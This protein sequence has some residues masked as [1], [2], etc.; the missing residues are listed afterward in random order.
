MWYK[1][2]GAK[3]CMHDHGIIAKTLLYKSLQES[4]IVLQKWVTTLQI[5]M[6]PLLPHAL[7]SCLACKSH[8]KKKKNP[9]NYSCNEKSTSNGVLCA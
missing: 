2:F 1:Y 5:L 9:V 4:K 7:A 6:Q 3:V 8:H